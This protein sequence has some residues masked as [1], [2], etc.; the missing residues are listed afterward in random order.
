LT[1]ITSPA[2]AASELIDEMIGAAWLLVATGI[3]KVVS[4][5]RKT[6]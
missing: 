3:S 2:L 5:N 6:A 4:A 1:S